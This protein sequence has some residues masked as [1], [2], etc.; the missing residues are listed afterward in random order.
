MDKI[1]PLEY[2]SDRLCMKPKEMGE[3]LIFLPSVFTQVTGI[4]SWEVRKTSSEV[5]EPIQIKEEEVPAVLSVYS[6]KELPREPIVV[7]TITTFNM[8]LECET[9]CHCIQSALNLLH[10]ILKMLKSGAKSNC[11]MNSKDQAPSV[12]RKGIVDTLDQDPASI[13]II[14]MSPIFPALWPQM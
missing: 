11:W 12:Q 9:M 13:C 7:G 10:R 3:I 14:L 2:Q 6:G 1:G 8:H 5:M 4:E